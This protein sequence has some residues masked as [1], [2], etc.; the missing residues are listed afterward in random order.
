MMTKNTKSAPEL[1]TPQIVKDVKI[2][3]KK[4]QSQIN[5]LNKAV[6]KNQLARKSAYS[7]LKAVQEINSKISESYQISMK[8]IIDLSTLL[9]QYVKYTNAI[10]SII[11][12]ISTKELS[13]KTITTLQTEASNQIQDI[14]QKFKN[15]INILK[16]IYTKNNIKTTELE[17][18]EKLFEK[19][20][21]NSRN[22]I[23]GGNMVKKK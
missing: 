18:Y 6:S 15:Q 8:I 9:N 10:E 5:R 14:S 1:S 3:D 12:D 11:K 13:N 4:L 2:S 21:M 19:I 16:P 7:K 20:S 22:L 23:Q 17:N